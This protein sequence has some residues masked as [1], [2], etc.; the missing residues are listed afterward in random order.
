MLHYYSPFATRHI[1]IQSA[2]RLETVMQAN[3]K[4]LLKVLASGPRIC[5]S[6]EERDQN[7]NGFPH[8]D[9]FLQAMLKSE[10]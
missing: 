6:L 7:N 5:L 3:L 4:L 2:F 9:G 10:M 8:L 1:I